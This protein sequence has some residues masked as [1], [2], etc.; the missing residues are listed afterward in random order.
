MITH[1]YNVVFKQVGMPFL[2][3]KT[4]FYSENIHEICNLGPKIRKHEQK[5]VNPNLATRTI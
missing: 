2:F 4:S 5:H 1:H 3:K